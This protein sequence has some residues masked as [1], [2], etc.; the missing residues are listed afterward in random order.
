MGDVKLASLSDQAAVVLET[1][2][3]TER[4]F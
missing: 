1:Y 3:A 2:G 4:L